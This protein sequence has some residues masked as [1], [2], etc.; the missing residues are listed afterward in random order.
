MSSPGH[1][2]ETTSLEFILNPFK[3]FFTAYVVH[4]TTNLEMRPRSPTIYVRDVRASRSSFA[5]TF[6]YV[7]GVAFVDT[8]TLPLQLFALE[9]HPQKWRTAPRCLRPHL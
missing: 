9:H 5:P 7:A 8:C 3:L 6:V 1:Y 2:T 4:V